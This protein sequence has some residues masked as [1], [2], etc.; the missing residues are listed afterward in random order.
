M[1]AEGTNLVT[2]LQ[3][4]SNR[5]KKNIILSLSLR[6]Q[7]NFKFKFKATISQRIK[8][9]VNEFNHIVIVCSISGLSNIMETGIPVTEQKLKG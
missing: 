7:Y 1:A 4:S 3:Q 9:L 6:L 2:R 8:G 5:D